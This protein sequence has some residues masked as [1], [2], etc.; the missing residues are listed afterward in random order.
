MI[1][2]LPNPE[3]EKIL[4][5]EIRSFSKLIK[6]AT[7]Y[8][9]NREELQ[10]LTQDPEK[11]ILD[12]IKSRFPEISNL[13]LSFKKLC[14]LYDVDFQ[15]VQILA[16]QI[17]GHQYLPLLKADLKLDQKKVD[18]YI[19]AN[20]ITVLTEQQAQVYAAAQGISKALNDLTS[21]LS[22]QGKRYDLSKIIG[23]KNGLMLW[24]PNLPF[25]LH[26]A[27]LDRL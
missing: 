24:E 21:D 14:G 17:L 3:L 9:T 23:F 20:A 26:L 6:K 5:S 18:D 1:K 12:Q 15:S 10:Q 22:K 16:A 27:H 25:I 4:I 19:A 13:G 2:Q 7:E 11:Y 8:A